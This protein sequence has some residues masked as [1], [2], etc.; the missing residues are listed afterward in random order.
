MCIRDRYDQVFALNAANGNVIWTDT[1]PI[2]P[3]STVGLGTGT[4]KL[5]AHTGSEQFT[6]ALF[7]HTPTL[8]TS[9]ADWKVYAISA[10]TGKY[11][12]NF[13]I[14]TGINMIPGNSPTSIYHTLGPANILVDQQRGIVITSM[15]AEGSADNG[16]C[17]YRGWNVLVTPPTPLWTSYCTPPQSGGNLPLDPNWDINQV[18]SMKSAEIFYPGPY[19]QQ[20]GGGYIPNDHGQAVVN[21]K[22]LSPSVLN[23]TLY[24]DWGQS[25]QSA[26]CAAAT[27][28]MSTGSTGAGWGGSWV[29]GKGPSSG[30]AFVN[31]NNKDPIGGGACAP[32]PDLWAASFMAI[33]ETSGQWVWGIQATAHDIWDYDCSW[34]QAL[35]N[36]T[37]NGVNTQV[38]LKSCKVYLFVVNAVTGDLLWAFTPPQTIIPRCPLCYLYN[39]LNRTQM[40]QEFFNPTLQPTLMY[41]AGFGVYES[42]GSYNPALNYAFFGVENA[43]VLMIYTPINASN[44]HTSIGYTYNPPARGSSLLGT[45]DNTTAIAINMATGQLVWSHFIASQGYRGGV[46]S[47]GNIVFLTLSSGDLLMLNAKTGDVVKDLFIGGP[48][49]ILPSIGATVNGQ[50]EIIAPITAGLVSWGSGV[51]GDLVA[52]TLQNVPGGGGSVVT[53][54]ATTTVATTITTSASAGFDTTTVYG[55]AAVAVIFIIAT[56]YLAI[57]GR[58]PAS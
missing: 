27:G 19:E 53:T 40:T 41:P 31:T 5:H 17:F 24:N 9:A 1:L 14:F 37:I 12:L 56:G 58:K 42:E 36:E 13:S 4:L 45:Q 21:L 10:L 23:S 57:R 51:P 44:Y 15:G 54:T 38:L 34:W 49:N 33:N 39:P 46:T 3:N 25:N 47:S 22:T 7:N 48:L 30:L 52:I 50:M 18:N 32:G 35:A 8:W 11:E 55:I 6:T 26:S 20:H 2:L 28:G 43:P 29:L 16:R